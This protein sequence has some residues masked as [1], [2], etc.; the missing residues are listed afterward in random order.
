MNLLNPSRSWNSPLVL[1]EGWQPTG[2]NRHTLGVGKRL[3][4]WFSQPQSNHSAA[5]ARLV[6]SG[7]INDVCAELERL[8]ALE[9]KH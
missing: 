6:L 2:A 3:S 8:A 9:D 4:R 1:I 5:E 7:R